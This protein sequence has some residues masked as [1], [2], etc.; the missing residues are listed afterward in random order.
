MV[1]TFLDDFFDDFNSFDRAMERMTPRRRPRPLRQEGPQ[2]Y[3]TDVRE[4]DSTYE[5]DIDL[6][7]FSKDEIAR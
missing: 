5:L 1:K 4:T 7:G 6:P 2:P 3:E